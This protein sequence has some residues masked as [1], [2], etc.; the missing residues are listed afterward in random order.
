MQGH[1]TARRRAAIAIAALALGAP[2]SAAEARPPLVTRVHGI[3]TGIA[4]CWR[5]PHDTDQVTVRLSFTRKGGVIDEP[6]I[7]FVHSSGGRAGEFRARPI[8]AEGDPRLHAVAFLGRAWLGDRGPGAGHSLHR[9]QTGD[10]RRPAVT[11][12]GR[13]LAESEFRV[14]AQ[15]G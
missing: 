15:I 8:H 1:M 4:A 11:N 3:A 9:P 10:R 2:A 14:S 12:C 7:V 6:R 5:P 13:L